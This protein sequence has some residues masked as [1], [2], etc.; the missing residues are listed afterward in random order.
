MLKFKPFCIKLIF[1]LRIQKK[2]KKIILFTICAGL[3]ITFCSCA[4]DSQEDLI[5]Q[6]PIQQ[7]LTYNDNIKSI[8]D[9]N[10]ISCHSNPPVNGAPNPLNDYE[11]VKNNIG[12]IIV[13]ISMQEGQGGLMP[14]GGP[15]L[16]QNLIDDIVQWETDGLLE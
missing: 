8:I 14:S 10:C 1:L 9:N 15:R 16:P 12:S 2:M 11:S 13:R 6:T 3:I 5:E 4:N 7:L